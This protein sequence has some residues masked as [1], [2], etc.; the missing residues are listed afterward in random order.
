MKACLLNV[1]ILFIIFNTHADEYELTLFST[2]KSQALETLNNYTFTIAEAEGNWQDS[3]GDYGKSKILFYLETADKGNVNIKGLAEFTS[4]DNQKFWM[5]TNRSYT[6]QDAGVG[7]MMPIDATD[8]YKFLLTLKCQYAV[9][10][11]DDRSYIKLRC[12]N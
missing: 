10:Y 9:N 5:L 1:L 6:Q 4:H 2:H 8:K 7:I 3:N 11:Y 12:I